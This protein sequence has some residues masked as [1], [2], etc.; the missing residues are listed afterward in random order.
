MTGPKQFREGERLLAES[1]T[2]L[3]P[4]DEGHCEADRTLAAAQVRAT[5]A[6]TLVLAAL[7]CDRYIGD[8]DHISEW[9][10]IVTGKP[11]P[12]LT[13]EPEAAP[14]TIYRAEHS[15]SGITLGHY[16]TETAAR[17]HCEA[18]ERRSWPKT[19]NLAFDWIED[20]DE[21]IAELVV[22]AGQAA[23]TTTGY[24]VTALE[25]ASE[26]DEEADE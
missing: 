22:A 11:R 12:T 13:T 16:G 1:L 21:G 6:N 17:A 14:T 7:L 4:H 18:V 23:E 25:L 8:G 5:N 20:E 3:R 26:F 19:V 10:A 15:D 24:A 2:I 9:H